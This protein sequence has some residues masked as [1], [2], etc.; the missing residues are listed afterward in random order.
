MAICIYYNLVL[1]CMHGS[2][3]WNHLDLILKAS[4]SLLLYSS[5]CESSPVSNC[6]LAYIHEQMHIGCVQAK[7]A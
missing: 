3:L 5:T 7:I 6:K 2:L 4:M 1:P